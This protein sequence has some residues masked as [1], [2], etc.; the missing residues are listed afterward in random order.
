[1]HDE[2]DLDPN[3]RP[4]SI[5]LIGAD[6]VYG[7]LLETTAAEMRG[8]PLLLGR[9]DSLGKGL[10]YL[11]ESDIDLVL[12][13]LD[14]PDSRGIGTFMRIHGLAPEVPVVVITSRENEE[15]SM[16]VIEEGAQNCI[17]LSQLRPSLFMR[18]ILYSIE[19]RGWKEYIAKCH[20]E[21]NRMAVVNGSKRPY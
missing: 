14:L 7:G 1:M 20:L 19:R 8:I 21:K 2:W 4:I 15:L 6:S 11:A 12:L 10:E 3:Y 13:D 18:S 5:L 16:K 9:A 17:F